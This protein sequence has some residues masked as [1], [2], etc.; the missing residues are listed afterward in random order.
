M[1]SR[2]SVT[3][4]L[5]LAFGFCTDADAQV[6][7]LGRVSLNASAVEPACHGCGECNEC[8]GGHG[9]RSYGAHYGGHRGSHGGLVWGNQ[10]FDCNP[11][12]KLFPPCPNSCRTTLLGEVVLGV[13]HAVDTGLNN[14][15]HCVFHCGHCSTCGSDN[16]QCDEGYVEH[17]ED[18]VVVESEM[19]PVP[20]EM[21]SEKGDPFGDDPQPQ[22]AAK[23]RSSMRSIM[24]SARALGPATKR[25]AV[26]PV[27]NEQSSPPRVR[28][29]TSYRQPTASGKSRTRGR[30]A[31]SRRTVRPAPSKRTTRPQLRQVGY[32]Q[33]YSDPALRFRGE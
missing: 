13:K 32:Q 21:N 23:A 16:C 31:A 17:Y 28:G 7:K 33:T 19:Q 6:R 14:A 15:F 29:K 11:R 24:P 4:M 10:C 1:I 18:G 8:S 2:R 30:S 25:R 27:S 9:G 22:G 12:H 26:R 20:A 3:M 5:M